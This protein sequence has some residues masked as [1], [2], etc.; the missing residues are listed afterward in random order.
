IHRG[1][2]IGTIQ[3]DEG[4]RGEPEEV[5]F[6]SGTVAGGQPGFDNLKEGDRVRYRRYPGKVGGADFAEDVWPEPPSER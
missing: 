6:A 5:I 3:P 4:Q 2:G 1:A